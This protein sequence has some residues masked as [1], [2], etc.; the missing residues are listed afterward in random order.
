[1]SSVDSKATTRPSPLIDGLMLMPSSVV[2]VMRR[3][4]DC[5]RLRRARAE[6]TEH[7]YAGEN[8]GEYSEARHSRKVK[9]EAR[10]LQIF[11]PKKSIWHFA[12]IDA[13]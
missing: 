13:W 4:G 9:I 1:M 5:V 12:R 10:I 6:Q 8:E 7:R 2:L 11:G 3:S